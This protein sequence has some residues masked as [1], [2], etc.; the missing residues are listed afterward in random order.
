MNTLALDRPVD[1]R[2]PEIPP[3]RTQLV[4]QSYQMA[5]QTLAERLLLRQQTRVE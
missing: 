3:S 1:Y 2:G 5:L 4:A